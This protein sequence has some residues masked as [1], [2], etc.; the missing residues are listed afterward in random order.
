MR[1]TICSAVRTAVAVLKSMLVDERYEIAVLSTFAWRY[2]MGVSVES[3]PEE[4]R[5]AKIVAY[6]IVA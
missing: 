1:T 5:V 3:E 4:W 6:S 2:Q